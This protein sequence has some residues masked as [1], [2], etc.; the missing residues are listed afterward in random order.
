MSSGKNDLLSSLHSCLADV[1]R[2]IVDA[3]RRD[4]NTIS[5]DYAEKTL[6]GIEDLIIECVK[7]AEAL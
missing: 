6:K 1:Q 3:E 7:R 5:Q 2:F 4:F